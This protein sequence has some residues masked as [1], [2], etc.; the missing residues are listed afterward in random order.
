MARDIAA[1]T[2]L[3]APPD[4]APSDARDVAADGPAADRAS[5]G[6]GP[7]GGCR[8]R[9]PIDLGVFF[10]GVASNGIDVNDLDL[11]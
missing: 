5:D 1:E 9:V 10:D 7:D 6:G 11:S 4:V 8:A 3:D 2:V